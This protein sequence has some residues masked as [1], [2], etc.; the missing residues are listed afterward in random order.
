MTAPATARPVIPD[1]GPGLAEQP[2]RVVTLDLSLTATGIAGIGGGGAWVDTITTR[3]TGYPRLHSIRDVVRSYAA[4]AHLVV[5]EGPSYGSGM[6]RRE[7]GHHERA[8]LWWLI[9]YMLWSADIPVAVMPPGA[10]KRYATGRGNAD[11][12]AVMLAAARRYPDVLIANNNEG[13]ALVM[14]AAALDHLGYP[15]APVPRTHR[16]ALAAVD[17]PEVAT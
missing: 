7:K 6:G 14:L 2:P 5:V 10:V 12:D 8:G 9:T 3:H 15:L 11:K 16:A 13:D 17:W 4:H 1:K